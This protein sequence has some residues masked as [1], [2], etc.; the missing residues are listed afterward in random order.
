MD[1]AAL[2]NIAAACLDRPEN[3]IGAEAAVDARAVGQPLVEAP[4]LL[5]VAAADDPLFGEYQ[6]PEV[7]G[8]HHALPGDWLPGARSVIALFLPYGRAW[9][10]WPGRELPPPAGEYFYGPEGGALQETIAKALIAAIAA[11][12]YTAL[13]PRLDGRYWYQ[14]S[15]RPEAEHNFTSN[16][17]ERH[18]AYAAGL[19]TFS[20]NRG[21]IT[22]RGMAGR[23]ISL[24]SDLPLPPDQRP[25]RGLTDYCNH[26]GACIA[27]CPQ[28]AIDRNGKRHRPCAELLD[29][30]RPY[31]HG[32]HNCSACQTRVPCATRI[33]KHK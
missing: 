26:C 14:P 25:Y 20:L 19:G 15:Y 5:K 27:R 16:W 1:K 6:R 3:R 2:L 28:G 8:P 17:S 21:L 23:L 32:E 7:I 12:G 11:A 4:L 10:S 9:R 30:A 29:A 18:V 31:Y 13:A 24:V 22:A 33:P